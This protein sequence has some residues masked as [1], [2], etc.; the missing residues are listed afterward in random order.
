MDPGAQGRLGTLLSD[1]ERESHKFVVEG[2][3]FDAV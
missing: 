1:P 3:S 2:V